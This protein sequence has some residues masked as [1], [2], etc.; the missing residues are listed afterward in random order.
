MR[1]RERERETEREGEEGEREEGRSSRGQR[2]SYL[3]TFTD[4]MWPV[5][6]EIRRSS[7]ARREKYVFG[8]EIFS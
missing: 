1:E 2:T 5:Y 8:Q 7:S 6:G 4:S 3:G